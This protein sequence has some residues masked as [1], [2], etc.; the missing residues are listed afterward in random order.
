MISYV[1]PFAR[2]STHLTDIQ[3][4][5]ANLPVRMGGL[6]V[7]CVTMLA[8]SAFLASAAGTRVL[9][10]RILS[11]GSKPDDPEIDRRLDV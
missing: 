1:T 5:Q 7:C 2:S 4:Q 9:Q 6:G 3:W 11:I 8:S 10:N